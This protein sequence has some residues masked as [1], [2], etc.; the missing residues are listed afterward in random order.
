[1]TSTFKAALSGIG[2]VWWQPDGPKLV[3]H[4]NKGMTST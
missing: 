1:M 3:M 4:L 2:K